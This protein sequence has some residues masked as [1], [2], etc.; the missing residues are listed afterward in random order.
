MP[1]EVAGYQTDVSSDSS[2][3]VKV[4]GVMYLPGRH[5]PLSLSWCRLLSSWGNQEG[6]APPREVFPLLAPCLM[7]PPAAQTAGS[8]LQTAPQLKQRV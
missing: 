4:T 5:P 8:R 7:W 6:N 3:I 2:S 1:L